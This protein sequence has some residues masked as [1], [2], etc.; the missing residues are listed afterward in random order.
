[1]HLGL[2][3][4][5]R[6]PTLPASSIA[7]TAIPAD[8]LAP[9]PTIGHLPIP[10]ASVDRV[11]LPKITLPH[12]N[13]NFMKWT[14]CWD[15]FY[16]AVHTNDRLAEVDKFNYLGSLLEGT[17]YDAIAGLSMTA[18]NY[19]EAVE[20][21]KKFENKQLIISRL[22]WPRDAFRIRIIRFSKTDSQK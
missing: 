8:P 19:K 5:L 10:V 22:W 2:Y 15:S 9:S 20:I 11:K 12:F 3:Q 4:V 13:G 21:L 16:S 1:M 6:P 14:S 17:A 7:S 18:S